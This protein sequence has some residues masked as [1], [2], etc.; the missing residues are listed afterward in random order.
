VTIGLR[1]MVLH[2]NFQ[3]PCVVHMNMCNFGFQ[4][5]GD[6]LDKNFNMHGDVHLGWTLIEANAM[7][8]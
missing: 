3:K 6:C 7:F 8:I 2:G 5:H 1:S 4:Q